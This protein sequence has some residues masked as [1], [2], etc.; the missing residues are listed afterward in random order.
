MLS[1]RAT[2]G[3]FR[4]GEGSESSG[5]LPFNASAEQLQAALEELAP[6]GPGNVTVFGGPGDG[7]GTNPYVISFKGDLEHTD[8][9]QISAKNGTEPLRIALESGTRAGLAE[10]S[11]AHP[12]NPAGSVTEETST[13]HLRNVSVK[14]P[15]GMTLN[16]PA[17]DGLG[18]CSM[19]QV[20]IG[21]GGQTTGDPPACPDPSKIGTVRVVTP[22]LEK[23][24]PGTIYLAEEHQNPFDSL[25]AIYLVVQDPVSGIQVKLAGRVDPDPTTGQLTFTFKDNPELPIEDLDIDLFEGPRAPLKTP[26]AC[27][28][29]TTDSVLTP[30]SSPSSRTPNSKAHSRS[31]PA[32]TAGRVRRRVRPRSTRRPSRP[33]P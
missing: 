6:I 8:V 30:W 17:A 32:P 2:Q 11:T 14:L 29:H 15:E 3:Q 25:L 23:P 27:G 5:D 7:V 19:A 31:P 33:A 4:V 10:V 18:A 16:P 22:V 9:D 13:S 1:V 21:P 26:D 24:L 20:G 28:K 12:G